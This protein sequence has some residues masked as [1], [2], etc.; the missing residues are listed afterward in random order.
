MFLHLFS[1]VLTWFNF[2]GPQ[3][4]RAEL[5]TFLHFFWPVILE[6]LTLSSYALWEILGPLIVY[7]RATQVTK[8]KLQLHQLYS[9][10][11]VPESLKVEVLLCPTRSQLWDRPPFKLSNATR[12]HR[13]C[14]GHSNKGATLSSKVLGWAA[15]RTA[16]PPQCSVVTALAI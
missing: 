6:S 14:L 9:L 7:L 10:L 1:I 13:G 4:G 3:C 16:A 5:P 2:S 12:H 15:T 8:Y 11:K